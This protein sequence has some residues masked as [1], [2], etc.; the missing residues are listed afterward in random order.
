MFQGCFGL[1]IFPTWPEPEPKKKFYPTRPNLI[2][3]PNQTLKIFWIFTSFI[4]KKR[5]I[6]L[7]KNC[8]MTWKISILE[9]DLQMKS[10][11]EFLLAFFFFA[12]FELISYYCTSFTTKR[13]KSGSIRVEPEPE[14]KKTQLDP[15][16]SNPKYLWNV[17]N[18]FH[19][20]KKILSNQ[21]SWGGGVFFLSFIKQ[22]FWWGSTILLAKRKLSEI[23]KTLIFVFKY[24]WSLWV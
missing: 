12:Y 16:I 24:S 6:S 7:K 17:F 2:F 23:F 11:F 13:S 4:F 18:Y 20:W 10:L 9:P 1:V 15:K 5:K 22:N 21:L 3:N 14:H 19:F 8:K